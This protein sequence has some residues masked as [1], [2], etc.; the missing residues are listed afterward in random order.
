[1]DRTTSIIGEPEPTFADCTFAYRLEV[2]EPDG[3]NAV[4]AGGSKDR[5][6]R[7]GFAYKVA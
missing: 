6:N 1:M 4:A 2:E 3:H 7:I 5:L